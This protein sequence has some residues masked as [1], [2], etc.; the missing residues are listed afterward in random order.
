MHVLSQISMFDGLSD[1]DLASIY[2]VAVERT[3]GK[4]ETIFLEDSPGEK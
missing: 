3:T 1:E 2:Q 4:G